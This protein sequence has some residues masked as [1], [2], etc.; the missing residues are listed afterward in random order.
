M[1]RRLHPEHAVD[2]SKLVRD[3]YAFTDHYQRTL[4]TGALIAAQ[5]PATVADPAVGDGTVLDIAFKIRPFE[6]AYVSDLSEPNIRKLAVSY[7]HQ[8]AVGDLLSALNTIP[9]VDVI[10]LT[11][12][13]EH[14]EDPDQVLSLARQKAKKLVASSPIEEPVGIVNSEHL[15]SFGKDGYHDMLVDTG[16]SP[17]SY[18]EIGFENTSQFYYTYQLWVAA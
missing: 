10:V 11:E 12:I 6:M 18:T 7:P 4:V 2:Y 8:K 9:E 13:L 16:W 3:N 15:W 17:F 14:L 1:R 5:E